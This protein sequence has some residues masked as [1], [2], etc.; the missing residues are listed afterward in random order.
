MTQT[1]MTTPYAFRPLRN[2]FLALCF[3]GFCTTACKKAGSGSGEID[4][5]DQYVGTYDGGYTTQTLLNNALPYSDEAGKVTIAVSKSQA[6]DELYLDF[7]FNSTTKE[8]RT[9]QLT[10]NKF[11][12][13]D[14]Q[15]ETI[16]FGTDSKG[17]PVGY[18]AAYTAN[19]QFTENN[20]LITTKSEARAVSQ[21]LTK[22]GSITCTKK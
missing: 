1:N 14:K 4:P 2:L 18:D 6:I 7:T 10:E 11:T 5:R 12:I 13:T 17:S 8:R 22:N 21:L 15:S 9:A 20:L 19:G 16:Y 3:I